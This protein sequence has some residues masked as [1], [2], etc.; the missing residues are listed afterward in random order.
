MN[1]YIVYAWD[2]EGRVIKDTERTFREIE[3]ARYYHS[4][5]L[6]FPGCEIEIS[7]PLDLDILLKSF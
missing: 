7:E 6:H 2:E 4:S 5:L 3:D 1:Y